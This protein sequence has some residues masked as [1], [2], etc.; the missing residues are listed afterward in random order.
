MRKWAL[1]FAL[2]T[3]VIYFT[4]SISAAACLFAHQ[5]QPRSAHHH[6]GGVSHSSLCAWACQA[7]QQVDL[8]SA[9]PQSQPLVFVALFLLVSA[10]RP[11]VFFQQFAQSRAPPRS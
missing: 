9:T 8:S 5:G 4:L 7:N 1:P 2:T 6:T 10:I 3:A 11:S